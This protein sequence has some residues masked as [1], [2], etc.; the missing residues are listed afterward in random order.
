[1][2]DSHWTW[3]RLVEEGDPFAEGFGHDRE[4]KCVYGTAEQGGRY[5]VAASK[6]PESFRGLR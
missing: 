6:H 2:D 3:I 5:D 1:M 4:V